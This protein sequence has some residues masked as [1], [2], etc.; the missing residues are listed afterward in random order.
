V[1]GTSFDPNL[2]VQ[3]GK[4]GAWW[5][6]DYQGLAAGGGMVYPLW[7]DTRTGR[8]EIFAA[9]VPADRIG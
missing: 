8:L 1:S 7:N 2:G 3:G 4:G 6:G 9:A 5:I